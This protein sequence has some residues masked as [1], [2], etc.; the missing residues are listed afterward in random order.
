MIP[1]QAQSQPHAA[2]KPRAAN[3]QH[4]HPVPRKYLE[5]TQDV[6]VE[7]DGFVFRGAGDYLLFARNAGFSLVSSAFE[8]ETLSSVFDQFLFPVGSSTQPA[9]AV[10][11]PATGMLL[12][13]GA[14]ALAAVRIMRAFHPPWRRR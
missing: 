5:L 8:G 11:E 4:T 13:A 10:P 12:A 9:A 2:R 6:I 14:A 3:V 7:P 1:P